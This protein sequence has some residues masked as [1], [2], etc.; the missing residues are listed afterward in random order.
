[1]SRLRWVF[2]HASRAFTGRAI[3]HIA[4]DESQGGHR[5]DCVM[6]ACTVRPYPSSSDRTPEEPVEKVI[7]HLR[8]RAV[9]PPRCRIL[10]ESMRI[11]LGFDALMRHDAA[12]PAFEAL[13]QRAPRRNECRLS[14]MSLRAHSVSQWS[15]PARG[16]VLPL[17][18]N[19]PN[20]NR[21]WLRVLSCGAASPIQRDSRSSPR[22]RARAVQFSGSFR[23]D[24]KMRRS[25][26]QA[27]DARAS[28]QPTGQLSR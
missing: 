22:I 1:V 7:R 13:S 27:L 5:S 6:L 17:E 14:P 4:F 9:A 26:T 28:H 20:E 10:G 23:E 16:P 11:R 3:R 24:V 15:K 18:P 8:C 19:T 12:T 25:R 21:A 2:V